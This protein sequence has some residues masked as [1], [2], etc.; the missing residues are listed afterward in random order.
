[1]AKT[2]FEKV[3]D[4]H[5]V[6]QDPGAPAVLYIDA[7]LIHEVTSPQAFNTLRVCDSF[8]GSR[9]GGG[10]GLSRTDAD[11]GEWFMRSGPDGCQGH[12]F[13]EMN[14]DLVPGSADTWTI[15]PIVK[16]CRNR[17]RPG[18]TIAPTRVPPTRTLNGPKSAWKSRRFLKPSTSSRVNMAAS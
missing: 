11:S 15:T 9:C 8:N 3:W 18:P 16:D 5:V 1:M 13:L 10:S 2:M 7:H 12:L 4:A 17:N 6:A 14:G